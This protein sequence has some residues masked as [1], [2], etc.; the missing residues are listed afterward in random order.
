MTKLGLTSYR[1]FAAKVRPL[2]GPAAAP[3]ILSLGPSGTHIVL[4]LCARVMLAEFRA[5]NLGTKSP[6]KADA[7]DV[8]DIFDP[9]AKGKYAYIIFNVHVWCQSA[10]LGFC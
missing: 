4:S 6:A 5:A 10:R 7:S 8:S 9:G 2:R 3:E 1:S